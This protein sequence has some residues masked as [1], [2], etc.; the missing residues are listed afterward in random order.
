MHLIMSTDVCPCLLCPEGQAWG[1]R[2]G[3]TRGHR[4]K[5]LGHGRA[6]MG[7]DWEAGQLYLS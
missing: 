5:R 3:Q 7:A 2:K 4:Q 6:C 1:H